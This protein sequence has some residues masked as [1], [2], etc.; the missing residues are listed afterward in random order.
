LKE[1][2][3]EGTG[4]FSDKKDGEERGEERVGPDDWDWEVTPHDVRK[5]KKKRG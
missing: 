5:G 2:T 1:L 3:V 4:R